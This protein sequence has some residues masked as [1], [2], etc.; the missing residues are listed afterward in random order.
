MKDRDSSYRE[1]ILLYMNDKL[2]D[3]GRIEVEQQMEQNDEFMLEYMDILEHESSIFPELNDPAQFTH[4]VMAELPRQ[5]CIKQEEYSDEH[6]G[7]KQEDYELEY[8]R[9]KGRS[10]LIHPITHYAIAASITLVLMSTG[11]FDHLFKDSEGALELKGASYS[12]QLMTKTTHWLDRLNR[13]N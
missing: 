9:V 4:N 5:K 7:I 6:Q 12:A 10:W 13:H 11:T 1:L 3:R 8:H 2:D